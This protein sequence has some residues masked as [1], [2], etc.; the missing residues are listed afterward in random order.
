[1]NEQEV[2]PEILGVLRSMD[3][4]RGKDPDELTEWLGKAPF[5]GGAE[6]CLRHF[7]A[8]E[9][10]TTAGTFGNSFYILIRGRVV[11]SWGTHSLATLGPG[12]FF[13]EMTLISGLPRNA[14]VTAQEPSEAIEIPRRA[15]E[16]WMKKPGPFRNTMDQIYIERGLGNHLR[17]IPDFAD[18][19]ASI[20][21][22][23]VKQ[24]KLRIFSKDEVIVREG[25]EADSFYLIREGY[26]RVVKAMAGGEQRIVAYLKDGS[27]FGENALLRAQRRNATIIAMGKVE[28]I[29]VTKD[30]F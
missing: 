8:G 9:E 16:Y 15:F 24:V 7:Q 6:C 26:V 1:M 13:G 5:E 19:D 10:I 22:A 4:L 25:D 28:V 2:T 18:L 12:S 27:Y 11:V 3:L 21:S 14:D 30:D 17:T 23:L 29:Q 20:I